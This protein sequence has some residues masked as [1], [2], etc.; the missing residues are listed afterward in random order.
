VSSVGFADADM[1]RR[2]LEDWIRDVSK[3][4]PRQHEECSFTVVAYA[5]EGDGAQPGFAIEVTRAPWK[6]S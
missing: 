1:L 6:K 3:E 4:P 5:R 2:R